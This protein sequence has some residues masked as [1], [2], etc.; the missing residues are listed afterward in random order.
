MNSEKTTGFR[1]NGGARCVEI[2]GRHRSEYAA[3]DQD[4]S[5][6]QQTERNAPLPD[7][8]CERFHEELLWH[9]CEH[10]SQWVVMCIAL[11]IIGAKAIHQA[12][13]MLSALDYGSVMNVSHLSK[14]RE[15]LQVQSG[16]EVRMRGNQLL[17]YWYGVMMRRLQGQ[18]S[19][20][21]H[22][23]P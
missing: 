13:W 23:G 1:R 4:R 22:K 17:G 19:K 20:A 18:I 8:S 9:F 3:P 10:H 2:N 21:G 5:P 16:S 7:S 14:N 12:H 15:R 11:Q 6:T